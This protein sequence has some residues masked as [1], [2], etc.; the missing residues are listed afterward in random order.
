MEILSFLCHHI[1]MIDICKTYTLKQTLNTGKSLLKDAGIE[2]FDLDARVLL[3]YVLGME[4]YEIVSHPNIE[5]PLKFYHQYMKLIKRRSNAEPVAQITKFKEF[6]SLP[7]KISKKTLIPRPD[8]ET[9]IEAVRSEF[10]NKNFAYKILDMG[11]GSGCLLLSLMSEF[12]DA[13]G[14]GIDIQ[15]GAVKTAKQNARILSF[16]DRTVILKQ[17]WHKKNPSKKITKHKFHIIISNPP[18]IT[19]EDMKILAKDVKKYEPRKA[20]F[21]GRDGLDEYRMLSQA[22]Y[23]W[24]ILE[25]GGKIFLEIGKGQELDVKKIFEAFGFKFE[26][27]FKD[28]SGII[29]VVEFSKK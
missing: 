8:S 6:W 3:S 21:G 25:Q 16:D 11:T 28:L 22:I 7:F 20:L 15:S 18:Y 9:M 17:N 29:R 12:R 1:F 26:K 24:N 14:V 5:V 27:S 19:G 2:S 4:S 10:K 13:F 23:D